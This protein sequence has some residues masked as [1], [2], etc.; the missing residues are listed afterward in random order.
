MSTVQLISGTCTLSHVRFTKNFHVHV[1]NSMAAQMSCSSTIGA[2]ESSEVSGSSS[3]G[4]VSEVSILD[5][6]RALRPSDLSRKR[7]IHAN[8]PEGK[9]RS[10][11]QA[12]RKFD[13][14]SIK[15]SQR[16]W[17][18]DI[19]CYW[20][21]TF[22]CCSHHIILLSPCNHCHNNAPPNAMGL[23]RYTLSATL[24][25]FIHVASVAL[26]QMPSISYLASVTLHQSCCISHLA[27]VLLHQSV[28]YVI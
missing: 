1:S 9:R 20:C 21:Y 11:T 13:P 2:S 5:K 28:L 22:N 25:P 8:P 18:I 7:K 14:Q 26:H 16:V 17:W 27:S 12:V 23:F 4:V 15:P 19:I 6:L 10:T 24:Y 3:D